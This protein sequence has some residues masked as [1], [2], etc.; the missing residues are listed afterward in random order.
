[1]FSLPYTHQA[2]ASARLLAEPRYWTESLPV[3]H[4]MYNSVI[5]TFLSL[6]FARSDSN[7]T[8]AVVH[9]AQ[10]ITIY[11]T[12]IAVCFNFT[13]TWVH[14]VGLKITPMA[15]YSTWLG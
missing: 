1:M 5:L 2:S 10:M 6:R 4:G 11:V 12:N 9:T 7:N 8:Q 13:T 3:G 15:S 14:A